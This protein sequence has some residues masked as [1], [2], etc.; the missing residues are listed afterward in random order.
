MPSELACERWT[1]GSPQLLCH[2]IK[3]SRP[4]SH[5]ATRS[6]RRMRQRARRVLRAAP[7]VPSEQTTCSGSEFEIAIE[8]LCTVAEV[9]SSAPVS[10]HER[11]QAV[12]SS[13]A[14]AS[15]E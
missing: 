1:V 2:V 5:G 12:I 4:N 6:G 9:T 15:Q 11:A 13:G 7:N 3:I 8:P 10:G 14:A